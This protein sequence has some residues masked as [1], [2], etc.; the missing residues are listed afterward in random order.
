MS[1][2]LGRPYQRRPPDGHAFCILE[3][4]KHYIESRLHRGV[5]EHVIGMRELVKENI[6]IIIPC[7]KTRSSR[8]IGSKRKTP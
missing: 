5:S 7:E 4:V 6:K 3:K 1:M 8:T 2:E